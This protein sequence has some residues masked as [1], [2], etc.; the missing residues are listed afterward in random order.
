M[1]TNKMDIFLRN[2]VE[3]PITSEEHEPKWKLLVLPSL[4]FIGRIN[5]EILAKKT[6]YFKSDIKQYFIDAKSHWK[7]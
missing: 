2:Y 7:Q 6:N 4:K 3:N 5:L 1:N